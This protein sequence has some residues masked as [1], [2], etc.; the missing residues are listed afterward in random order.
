MDH[1]RQMHELT[2]TEDLARFEVFPAGSIDTQAAEL[3][4]EAQLTV[5]C[6]PVHGPDRSLEVAG[7]LRELGHPV[8]V[9]V[10]ARMVR[11]RAHLDALLAGMADAGVDDLF[12]IGGD[13]K[14]Q[15]GEYSSAVELLPL[16][17]EH[18]QRPYTIGIAG[19]PEDH[20]FI[21][22]EEI[23]DALREKCRFADYVTTQMCFDPDALRDWVVRHRELGMKLH[24][25]IG[26]PGKVARRRLLKMSTQI[27]VGPSVRF[28]RKQRGLL[29]LLSRRSTADR[30]YDEFAPMLDEPELKLAGFNYY[31]FNQ[32]LETWEW[33]QH[34]LEASG[35]RS[36]RR[37]ESVHDTEQPAGA[38]GPVG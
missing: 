22:D 17:D 1:L 12:L 32:L 30:L 38:P 4:R 2:F 33:H 11:D 36:K 26:M 3:P 7:R 28:L 27:G 35:K 23:E 20:P 13:I 31:T 24:V 37:K 19:Y 18:P 34:K 15:Q 9:H 5:T 10:A 6:S 29:S 8:T 14:E 25:V 16:I 21:S